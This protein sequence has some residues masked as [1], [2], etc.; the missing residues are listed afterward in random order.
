MTNGYQKFVSRGLGAALAKP[1]GLPRPAKLRR[2]RAGDPLLQGPL[3]LIGGSDAAHELSEELLSWDVDVRSH[4]AG[5]IRLGG[6]L[7]MLDDVSSPSDLSAPALELADA[8]RRLGPGARV[9]VVSR[10]ADASVGQSTRAARQAVTGLVR[11]LAHEMRGGATANGIVVAKDA[12]V[13]APSVLGALRFLL[14]GRS[15]YVDGQFLTVS[16]SRGELPADSERPLAGKVAVVTGAA[17]GIGAEIAS[18]LSRDGATVVSVDVPQAGEALAAVTN[19]IGG[20]AL[21]LD[22]TRPEAG[23]VILDHARSRHGGLDIV[24]HNAGIT[25]DKLLV[26]MGKARWDSVMA[27]NLESQL[28]MNRTFEAAGLTG[29]RIVSLASTSG[30]A[31]NRGQTNYGASKAGVI[32]LV[33]AEA[34]VFSDH[35]GGVNAVAPG[36]IETD[37]TA[38][39]PFGPKWAGRLVL[40]S[41]QQ[42]GLPRDV[43][44]GVA[45]LAS[46]AAAG[47]NGSVLRVCGQSLIG[48]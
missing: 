23:Q 4:D 6:I 19:R 47:I 45:F 40:P 11:S 14:S 44:E 43:A 25:R 29:L 7:V 41:L 31:G 1:L 28:A 10:E 42:G 48:A 35:F 26:N 37:M 5:D 33:E 16:G 21:Q 32:G 27:V 2:F 30:I 18:V 22:V 46:D 13:T 9:V 39:M 17:R 20:T 36:F 38:K 15:A 24:V 34:E 8:V 12:P 3:Q